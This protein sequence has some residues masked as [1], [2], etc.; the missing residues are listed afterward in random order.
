M[1]T[2]LVLLEHVAALSLIWFWA[3]VGG[4][5]LTVFLGK[6]WGHGETLLASSILGAAYWAAALYLLPFAGGW[7]LA[8]SLGLFSSAIMI[9]RWWYSEEISEIASSDEKRNGLFAACL[10]VFGAATFSTPLITQYTP[11]GMD[12]SMHSTHARLIAENGTLP[13]TYGPFASTVHFPPVNQGLP[14][15]AAMAIRTGVAPESAI[16]ASGQYTFAILLLATY[17]L[18]RA[19]LRHIPSAVLAVAFTWLNRGAQDTIGWGGFPTI[20]GVAVA[21][22]A[23]RL[24]VDAALN[25]SIRLALP[26]GMAIGSIPLIH[27]MSASSWV[28]SVAPVFALLAW[29]SSADRLRFAVTMLA[30]VACS[31]VVVMAYMLVGQPTMT[32]ADL[33]WQRNW[34]AKF[35]PQGEGWELLAGIPDYISFHTGDFAFSLIF[36]ACIVLLATRQWRMLLAATSTFG[37]ITLLVINSKYWLIPGSSIICPLRTI[38]FLP[39]MTAVAFGWAWIGINERIR[40]NPNVGRFLGILLFIIALTQNFPFFQ[41]QAVRPMISRQDYQALKWAEQNLDPKRDYVQSPYNTAGSYLPSVAGIASTGWHMHLTN[42]AEHDQMMR[43]RR[44]TYIFE[45]GSSGEVT[46]SARFK[47]VDQTEQLASKDR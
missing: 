19:W 29:W 1:V 4:S 41:R 42:I 7:I 8:T 14:A 39:V 3:I 43:Q 32:E 38:Y 20:T 12:A 21:I 5:P 10:L 33:V 47:P 15:L 16:L 44:I 18:C 6:K 31:F 25:R 9:H 45:A 28:Y 36:V 13:A 2:P 40:L 26:M 35:I 24:M 37:L 46:A 30:T 27:G 34:Q 23:T 17:L 22:L 11:T